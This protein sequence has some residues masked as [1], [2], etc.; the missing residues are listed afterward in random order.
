[1]QS[2]GDRRIGNFDGIEKRAKPI[3]RPRRLSVD[4]ALGANVG[5]EPI[6]FAKEQD[7]VCMT[8]KKPETLSISIE[9]IP[10]LARCCRE[11]AHLAGVATASLKASLRRI[12]L[13]AFNNRVNIGAS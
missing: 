12:C 1:M 2:G 6:L 4:S 7:I 10:L 13:A 11:I 8:A 3:H 5:V 9:K